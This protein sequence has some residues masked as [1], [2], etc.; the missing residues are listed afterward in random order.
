MLRIHE[1]LLPLMRP[2]DTLTPHYRNPISYD[3]EEVDGLIDRVGIHWPIVVSRRTNEILFD[4][5]LYEAL[6]GRGEVEGPV[7]YVDDT[8]EEEALVMMVSFYA[9]IQEA[10]VDPG[11][12]LPLIKDLMETD[13]GLVGTG[14]DAS[15]FDRRMAEL[16]EGFDSH[17]GAPTVQCPSCKTTF[18]ID[19]MR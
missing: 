19:R 11:L 8:N 15:I 3:V 6:M 4:A 12:E 1:D 10:W 5:G 9:R 16:Q 17:E 7:L 18:E 2:L 14:Y 13:W